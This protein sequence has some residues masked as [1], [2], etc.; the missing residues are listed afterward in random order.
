MV[1]PDILHALLFVPA[2][3]PERFAKA[4]ASH[5]DAVILDLE[6]AVAAVDKE[7]ARTLLARDFTD[8]PV[9]VRINPVGTPWHAA[10]LQAVA[11]LRPDAV[12]LPKSENPAQVAAVANKLGDIA[13]LGLI[14]TARGLAD[15]RAIA[16]LDGVQRLV[17]GS[18]DFCADLGMSL[19]RDLLLPA[20][21]ELVLASRLAGIG[22]PIDGVT[23]R[24]DD[25]TAATGD[26]SHARALGMAGKLCIHPRQVAD[27]K[28]AFAPS[29][30]EIAW[31]TRVLAS[32][33][34]AVS[35]DGE[36]IDAPVRARARSILAAMK[37]LFEEQQKE[38]RI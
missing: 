1:M 36:M 3:R 7:T 23:T 14:E 28:S 4:A 15:A 19:D 9:I 34:G 18:V 16:T 6:D 12:L 31:A 11:A 21:F 29:E 20:R 35:L 27:V 22:A 25:P 33:D 17:F 8:L 37:P 30:V 2:N 13:L 24:L 26:A 38:N 5:P 32:G 10:D